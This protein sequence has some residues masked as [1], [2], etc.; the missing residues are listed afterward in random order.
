MTAPEHHSTSDATAGSRAESSTSLLWRVRLLSVVVAFSAICFRQSTGLVVP[1]TKLDLTADPGGFMARALNLWDPQGS[2]GQLQNQAYGYLFPVGPFHYALSSAGLPPWV[3]QRLWWTTIFATALLGMW[4]LTKAFGVVNPWARLAGAVGFAIAPRFVA[5]VA[6]TSVEVWPMAMAPWVLLPLVVPGRTTRWRVTRSALAFLLVGAVNAVAS[7]ATLVLPV[8]WLLT[9]RWTR[10]HARLVLAWGGLVSAVSVWWVVPLLVLGRYSPS[11]LAWI[12]NAT[13]TTGTASTFEAFR[14]TS[15]WLGFL[16]TSAGPSWPAAWLQITQPVLL[17]ASVVVA[18]AGL[19]GL[20]RPRERGYLLAGVV[21]GLALMTLGHVGGGT[22]PFTSFVRDLLDGPLAPM[23][24]THKF[25]LVSR[26]PL[27]VGL[28]FSVEWLGARAAASASAFPAVV[29]RAGPVFV[30]AC[31]LMTY[32]APALTGNMARHEGYRAI[33]GYWADA[34]RW[35]DKQPQEGGVL[36]TP[37]AAFA[38]FAWGSTKDEPFQSLLQ[39]PFV[40]RDAV[41]LGSAGATRML[42]SV[43][44]RMASGQRVDRLRNVLGGAGVAFVVVRNDL[45]LDAQAD[46]PSAVLRSLQESGLRRVATFGGPVQPGLEGPDRTVDYRSGVP[47]PAVEVYEVERPR[48]ARIV[49]VSG[50]PVLSGG[51]ENLPSLTSTLG[52]ADV[53]RDVDADAAGVT[54]KGPRVLT[55]GM[56]RRE[57]NFGLPAHNTSDLLR[58]GEPG[59]S[60]REVIDYD[61]PGGQTA[62]RWTDPIESVTASSSA[63]D[64]Y[65]TLRLGPGYGPAAALD[66]DLRTRWVSGSFGTAEGE[67]LQ[68]DFSRPTAVSGTTIVLSGE[69]PVGAVPKRVEVTTDRGVASTDAFAGPL[70]SLN[71]P[72][73]PARWMRVTLIDVEKGPQNGFSVSELGIP[74]VDASATAVLQQSGDPTAVLLEEGARGRSECLS[75]SGRMRCSPAFGRP[76]EELGWSRTWSAATARTYTST[77]LARPLDGPGL[78]RLLA[79]PSGLE[80]TAS[81]RLVDA[82]AGRP[83]AGIDADPTTGWVANSLDPLPWYQVELPR[84]RVVRGLTVF[85]SYELA[86]STPVAVTVTFDDGTKQT[87][88]ADED[89]YIALDPKRTRT[90]RLG[91]GDVRLMEN[92]DSRSGTRSFAPIG[93][94]EL[95]IHGA[96]RVAGRLDESAQTGV[97]CGFGPNLVIAGERLET[98]VSGTIGDVLHGRAMTWQ[99]CSGGGLVEI[100]QGEVRLDARPTA[101]FAPVSLALQEPGL[102]IREALDTGLVLERTSPSSV[103]VDVAAVPEESIL[104]LPQNYNRGWTAWLGDEPLTAL[105]VNGWQQGFV[106]P[107]GARGVVFAEFS[108]NRPYRLGL[109]AGAALVLVVLAFSLGTRRGRAESLDPSPRITRA[110]PYAAA[111]IAIG[112]GGVG[113]LLAAAAVAALLVSTWRRVAGPLLALV[114]LVLAASIVVARPYPR[115]HDNVDSVLVQ[116]LVWTAVMLV[117]HAVAR[118]SGRAA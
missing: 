75:I 80:A 67:W 60:G 4:F 114:P 21:V 73:G 49:P 22:W 76:F 50:M 79:L 84:A 41:P 94:S 92:V 82:P 97:P 110:L 43:M 48:G 56:R 100:P 118:R 7:L 62:L 101:E 46:P 18:G 42:D 20:V 104:V 63:S 98:A 34:A 106:L 28:A 51:P 32:A 44:D 88:R 40:V 24:N 66:G 68:V 2:L 17:M 53:L 37:S 33:P 87:A 12:E 115:Y 83:D 27:M 3:V 108:P 5:E 86:A 96:E 112:A 47:R 78:E 93:F 6:I 74:G 77:G 61:L 9:R 65:G 13:V 23:R 55:D 39:R 45:R 64:A 109:W 81:S 8:L 54:P 69:S 95:T 30:T 90:L 19:A 113:A 36:V 16:T 116:G 52:A 58:A 57:V 117:L 14:G 35:L 1:D 29:R 102:A 31:V 105:R 38:D 71:T 99:V 103:T 72:P 91:F 85:K 11:F 107:Q 15:A 59:R 26:L 89:G 25:E 70:T 10:R 111:L